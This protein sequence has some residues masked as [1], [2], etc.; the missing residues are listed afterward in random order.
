[1]EII[2]PQTRPPPPLHLPLLVLILALYLALAYITYA[3]EGFYPYSF[4]DPKKGSGRVTGYCFGILAAACIIFGV[5]WGLIWIRCWGTARLGLKAK[6]GPASRHGKE[7]V[8]EMDSEL[9]EFRM[10][11]K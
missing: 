7:D 4:L 2:L 3:T 10:N 1:M 9:A 6:A 8:R 5:V 11:D